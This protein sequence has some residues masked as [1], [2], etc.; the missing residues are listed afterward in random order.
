MRR[1]LFLAGAGLALLAASPRAQD[2]RALSLVE[3]ASLPRLTDPQ[4]APDGQSVLYTL[5]HADWQANRGVGQIWRQSVAGGAPVRL[6][7]QEGGATTPRW[8][9]R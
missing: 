7:N 8:P 9:N 4:L 5:T 3:L 1:L 2:P 6:T